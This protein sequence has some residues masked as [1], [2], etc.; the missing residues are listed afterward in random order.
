MSSGKKDP[1]GNRKSS[2]R[3]ASSVRTSSEKSDEEH[4]INHFIAANFAEDKSDELGVEEWSRLHE[5]LDIVIPLFVWESELT[6][7]LRTID[8]VRTIKETEN[9][10]KTREKASIQ[11]RLSKRLKD[12][13]EIVFEG[14]GDISEKRRG[15]LK[16]IIR[17][18]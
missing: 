2:R 14:L 13:N 6:E 18:K 10:R 17:I 8:F 15:D 4:I 1:H 9:P 7:Q 11:M 5:S 3:K 16:V 12:G